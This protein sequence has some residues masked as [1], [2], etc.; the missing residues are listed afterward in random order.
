MEISVR[1]H[2]EL[3]AVVLAFARLQNT[4]K[5][6]INKATRSTLNPIWQGEVR[7]NV[8]TRMDAKVVAAGVRVK[9]G[10][11][12]V[13]QAAQSVRAIDGRLRPAD[14]WQGWE[15]GSSSRSA[16]TTYTRKSKKGGTHKVTRH[17]MA[18]M[19]P[20]RRQGRV[21]YPAMAETVPRIAALW[22]QTVVRVVHEA[23]EGKSS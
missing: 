15:F 11:P 8:R 17:T 23:A 16:T 9:A 4:V 6:E 1:D 7:Q 10:N 18:Q 20:M 5:N 14:D 21:A 12:P 2:R 13:L 3:K 19:P 22:V